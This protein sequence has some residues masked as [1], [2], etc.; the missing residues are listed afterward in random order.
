MCDISPVND[1]SNCA[2]C[3]VHVSAH[4]MCHWF[5]QRKVRERRIFFQY[6]PVSS[7]IFTVIYIAKITHF[8]YF[9]GVF[10]TRLPTAISVTASD[11]HTCQPSQFQRE[12]SDTEGL[13]AR[14]AYTQSHSTW[15]FKDV[16]AMLVLSNTSNNAM[17]CPLCKLCLPT[18][19]AVRTI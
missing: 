12:T 16:F 11:N 17:H 6:T 13:L 14:Y 5:A 9:Y 19:T 8:N 4:S 18:R 3:K 10:Q 2:F 1:N 15:T 7:C